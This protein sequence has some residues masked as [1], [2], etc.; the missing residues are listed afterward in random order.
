MSEKPI[1]KSREIRVVHEIPI[2]RLQ[3]FW[4]GLKKGKI[5]TT[6]CKSCGALYFP[7]AADCSQ[8]LTSNM[9]WVEL[10]GEATVKTFTYV[11]IRP[12]TFQQTTP[13][14]V[15][16]GEL[17]EGVRVL[18]WLTGIDPSEVKV[19]MKVKL[20]AKTTADGNLLYEFVPYNQV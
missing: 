5:L 6:R 14:I 20:V 7:P 13:Y 12:E 11:S 17:K 4:D 2:S 15:A 16:I 9:D 8:C 18:A 10:S 19:G 3:K 1:I